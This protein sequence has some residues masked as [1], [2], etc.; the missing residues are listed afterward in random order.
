MKISAIT[1]NSVSFR[2]KLANRSL[3]A[4]KTTTMAV[5]ALVKMYGKSR[6]ISFLNTRYISIYI[7]DGC[8]NSTY[9]EGAL[10]FQG[11]SSQTSLVKSVLNEE[12]T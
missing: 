10:Q 4:M 3:L 2:R 12:V 11:G 9:P 6:H 1:A 5:V 7:K 8:S